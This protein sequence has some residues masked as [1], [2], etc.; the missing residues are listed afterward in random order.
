MGS[1]GAEYGWGGGVVVQGSGLNFQCEEVKGGNFDVSTGGK[2]NPNT[3]TSARRSVVLYSVTSEGDERTCF[4]G[5]RERSRVRARA[6][7]AN[8]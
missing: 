5:G 2:L 7:A 8:Q 6:S 3:Q 1:L 4:G